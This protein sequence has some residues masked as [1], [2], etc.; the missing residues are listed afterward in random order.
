MD[1]S[2]TWPT[3]TKEDLDKAWVEYVKLLGGA[4][5]LS[6]R[7]GIQYSFI[8]ILVSKMLLFQVL[9]V[10][11]ADNKTL[12][13]LSTPKFFHLLLFSFSDFYSG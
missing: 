11:N 10:R 8:V 4:H 7:L 3:V 13:Q 5:L 12:L 2:P 6:R 1:E 9:I